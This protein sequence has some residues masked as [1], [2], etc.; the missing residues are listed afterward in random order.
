MS[1]DDRMTLSTTIQD[2]VRQ[3]NRYQF[4]NWQLE[5]LER[6]EREIDRLIDKYANK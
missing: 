3:A 2:Y 5:E 6:C 1:S 4:F